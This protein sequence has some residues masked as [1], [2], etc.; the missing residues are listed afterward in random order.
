MEPVS[1]S[2]TGLLHHTFFFLTEQSQTVTHKFLSIFQ[3]CGR[4]GF[5]PP[6]VCNQI[7]FSLPFWNQTMSDIY[8]MIRFF[9]S[10]LDLSCLG[11]S[12]RLSKMSGTSDRSKIT[13]NPSA[14]TFLEPSETSKRLIQTPS[15]TGA[16]SA[17]QA[18]A[19]VLTALLK[20]P[21]VKTP[22]FHFF[23]YIKNEWCEISH[24]CKR[25]IVLLLCC[26]V[27]FV[28]FYIFI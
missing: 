11:E 26:K 14:P 12:H 24:W 10:V 21:A 19:N 1:W 4:H 22:G 9:R 20:F 25:F 16:G 8:Q 6:F 13:F 18:S 15:T 2:Q 23:I 28:L 5:Q 17:I 27:F 7:R 3:R